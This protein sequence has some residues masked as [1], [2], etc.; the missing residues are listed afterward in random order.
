MKTTLDKYKEKFKIDNNYKALMMI[1][2]D[3]L[4]SF[5]KEVSEA[6]SIF[7]KE[8][9]FGLK[10][11]MS[12]DEVLFT[13]NNLNNEQ[14]LNK[15][16]Q[17]YISKNKDI[18]DMQNITKIEQNNLEKLVEYKILVVIGIINNICLAD[19]DFKQARKNI[20]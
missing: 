18:N 4:Y 1:I 13:I 5:D 7:F 10:E 15:I 8:D 3:R 20:L 12:L 19:I 11:N 17:K 6:F 16:I 9:M 14:N 2:R